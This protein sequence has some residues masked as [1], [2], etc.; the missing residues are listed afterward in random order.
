MTSNPTLTKQ[1]VRDLNHYGPKPDKG[2]SGASKQ[3][4][5]DETKAVPQASPKGP[6]APPPVDDSKRELP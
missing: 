6:D 5:S 4:S 2:R 3:P 1:G